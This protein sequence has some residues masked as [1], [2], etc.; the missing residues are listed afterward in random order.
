M[1]ILQLKPWAG[2]K[3]PCVSWSGHTSTWLPEACAA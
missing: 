3:E 1:S 2:M